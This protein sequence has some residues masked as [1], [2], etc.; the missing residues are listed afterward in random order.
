[1]VCTAYTDSVSVFHCY[2]PLHIAAKGGLVPVVQDLISK[3]GS[4]LA[5]D[6]SG[7]HVHSRLTVMSPAAKAAHTHIELGGHCL[8]ILCVQ[9][10]A[11]GVKSASKKLC[12]VHLGCPACLFLFL[13]KNNSL[14]R[15]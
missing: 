6:E 12:S 15:L 10:Y 14:G 4:V 11:L 2:R 5:L 8:H 9:Q 3:G 1:M 13:R 7:E